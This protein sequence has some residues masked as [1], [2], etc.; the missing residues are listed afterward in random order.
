MEH[1]DYATIDADTRRKKKKKTL[2]NRFTPA[3]IKNENWGGGGK[4]ELKTAHLRH[5][6]QK[7]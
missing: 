1:Y 3:I 4:R 5:R 6:G 2:H 7:R